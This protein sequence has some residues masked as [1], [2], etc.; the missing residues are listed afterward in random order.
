MNKDSK[1]LGSF[2]GLTKNTLEALFREISCAFSGS[3]EYELILRNTHLGI[4]LLD[5]GQPY[6]DKL[7]PRVATLIKKYSSTTGEF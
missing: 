4:A 2:A 3:P 1:D 6:A 5:A 7:D